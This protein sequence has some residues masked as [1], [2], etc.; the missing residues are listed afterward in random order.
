MDAAVT[1]SGDLTGQ[2]PA[3][4]QDTALDLIRSCAHDCLHFPCRPCRHPI[5]TRG[6]SP[7][8]IGYGSGF[9]LGASFPLRTLVCMTGLSE[10]ELN[11]MIEEATVDCNDE[12]E[13]LTGFATLVEENLEVPFETTVLGV[14][15]T[16]TGV[17]HASHGLVADC[18]RGRH[19]QTIH[20]LDLPLPEPS[21]KGAEWITA[22]RRWAR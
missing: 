9:G 8:K 17:T 19:R 22:Y 10:A 20:V 2:T 12:E 15:V 6:L 18:A 3:S 13:A 21:P 11:A 14:K 7:T 5:R 4:P 16:V 1:V